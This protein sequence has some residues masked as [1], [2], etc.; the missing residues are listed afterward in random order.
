MKFKILAVGLILSTVVSISL[1]GCS[2]KD[3]WDTNYTFDTA[4]IDLHNEV[5][6]VEVKQWRDYDDGEQLQI[7]AKDGTVYLTSSYNCTLIRRK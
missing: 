3:V 2:N 6:T 5:I 7:I 1:S 4:I